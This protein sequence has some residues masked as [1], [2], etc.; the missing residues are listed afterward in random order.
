MLQRMTIAIAIGVAVSLLI[1]MAASFALLWSVA[2]LVS[3]VVF[4]GWSML[5]WIGRGAFRALVAIGDVAGRVGSHI[6]AAP[7]R[8]I[9][10]FAS[11]FRN[12][13]RRQQPKPQRVILIP[14]RRNS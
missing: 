6:L 14:A 10:S 4:A 11:I 7:G 2:M 12:P 13:F 1:G 3:T 9:R 5:A 8:A